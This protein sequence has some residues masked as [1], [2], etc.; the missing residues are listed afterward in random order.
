MFLVVGHEKRH[1]VRAFDPADSPWLSARVTSEILQRNFG[2]TLTGNGSTKPAGPKRVARRPR[3]T[4]TSAPHPARTTGAGGQRGRCLDR[5]HR[6][7]DSVARAVESMLGQTHSDLLVSP[8]NDSDVRP[9]WQVLGH[10]DDPRLVR[11][12]YSAS[13]VG[14]SSTRSH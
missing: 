7:R 8:G 4:L 12:D 5:V 10:L 2:I 3:S 13:G 14:T 11:I 9:R 6:E 1:R